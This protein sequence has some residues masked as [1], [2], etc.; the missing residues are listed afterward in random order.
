LTQ[1]K[2]DNEETMKERL[3]Q[4]KEQTGA[5]ITYY[6]AKGLVRDVNAEQSIDKINQQMKTY[7][8]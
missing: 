5:A 3:K 7:F 6:R 2:D 8:K 4:Y 1:R